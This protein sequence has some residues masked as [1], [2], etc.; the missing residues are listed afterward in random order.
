[1]PGVPRSNV[2]PCS[3]PSRPLPAAS[4]PI[5]RTVVVEEVGEQADRVRAAADAGDDRIGQ[6][7]ELV[8]HL[9]PR[10]AADHPLEFAHHGRE[11]MWPSGGAE[12]IMGCLEARRPVAQRLVD[13]VLE[14]PAA[15]STGTTVAPISC[16][17]KTLS[18][19]RSTSS[20]PM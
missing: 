13:R 15:A 6:A 9:R 17:R 4:T 12:Q 14:R 16:I 8:D 11:R 20:A 19:C 2:A 1:M 3:S 18:C 10:L 7:A 5:R